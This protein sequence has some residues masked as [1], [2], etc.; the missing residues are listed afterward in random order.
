MW[1]ELELREIIQK[2][3]ELSYSL[4]ILSL[5]EK[6]VK[7]FILHL[8]TS[9]AFLSSSHKILQDNMHRQQPFSSTQLTVDQ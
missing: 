4:Q 5:F 9:F 1:I 7:T 6:T 2:Y 8:Y 3:A